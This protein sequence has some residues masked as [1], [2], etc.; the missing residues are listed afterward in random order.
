M[1]DLGPASFRI[2][3]VLPTVAFGTDAREP[4]HIHYEVTADGHGTRI[5]EIVFED[6]PFLSREIRAE[7]A[8]LASFYA[9]Q[10]VRRGPGGVGRLSQDVVLPNH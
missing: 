2:S 6:D 3:S 9:L 4:K 7:A 10:P 1:R 8:R 5:F